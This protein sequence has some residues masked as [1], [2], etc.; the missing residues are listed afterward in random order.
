MPTRTLQDAT[1]PEKR[2]D[3]GPA[4][5][6]RNAETG[7]AGEDTTVEEADGPP[8]RGPLPAARLPS[9]IRVQARCRN[10]DWPRTGRPSR[11][12]RLRK[13]A[14]KRWRQQ[15]ARKE[16]A[17]RLDKSSCGSADA[18]KEAQNHR[19]RRKRADTRT[20]A[21]ERMRQDSSGTTSPLSTLKDA[22]RERWG[23]KSHVVLQLW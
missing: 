10:D 2:Q 16:L 17:R 13:R 15:Q 12:Q 3:A 5:A 22:L 8:F 19:M 21:A 6:K 7:D 9:R 23:L 4:S 11:E 20:F 1:R 18:Y 14:F